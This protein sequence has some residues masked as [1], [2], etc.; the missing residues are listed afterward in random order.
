[1]K[2]TYYIAIPN[3]WQSVI[4]S[5][6]YTPSIYYH[7]TVNRRR[8]PAT[9]S[10][11]PVRF[12]RCKNYCAQFEIASIDCHST[13]R[14]RNSKYLWQISVGTLLQEM[15]SQADDGWFY[16]IVLEF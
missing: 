6:I 5:S 11:M 16:E 2:T 3:I 8:L 14:R 15:Y 7:I 1:M 9:I 10:S 12:S 4:K 13:L